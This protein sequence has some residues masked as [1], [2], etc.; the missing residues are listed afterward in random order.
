MSE[1]S[2][3]TEERLA[4]RSKDQPPPMIVEFLDMSDNSH[5]KVQSIGHLIYRNII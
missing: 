5:A 4:K 1:M 3:S 2:L